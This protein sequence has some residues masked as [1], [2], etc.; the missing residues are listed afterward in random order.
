M[1]GS[2]ATSDSMPL[3]LAASTADGVVERQW[4]IEQATPD[5][6]ALGHLAQ[7]G[8]VERRLHLRIDRLDGGQDRDLRFLDTEGHGE[9]DG[10]LADIDLVLQRR[11]DVDRRV[12]D[13]QDLVVRRDVHDEHVADASAGAQPRLLGHDGTQQLV[14]VQAAFHQQL[15]LALSNQFDRFCR[16]GMTV[17]RVDN[18]KPA[19]RDSV[20]LRDLPDLRLRADENRPDEPLLAGLDRT[21][22]RRFLAGM[23]DSG[24]HRLEASTSSEQRF[25][26]SRSRCSIH[27]FLGL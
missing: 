15:G 5:L 12:G 23:G 19:E 21:R 11:R 1:S 8:R 25:V 16:R 3:I 7:R 9:I 14:A 2:P 26:F 20:R 27:G 4:T 13:H 6:P 18:P 22:Q 17:R 10:V 24:R